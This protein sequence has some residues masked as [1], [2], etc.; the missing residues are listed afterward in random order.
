MVVQVYYNEDGDLTLLRGKKIAIIG[1]GNQAKAF[2]L[3]MRD[4][5][6]P[7]VVGLPNSELK[8][9]VERDGFPLKDLSECIQ[10][11]D[12]L[13][14][15][16]SDDHIRKLFEKEIRPNL[17]KNQTI[18][19]ASGCLLAFGEIII[20]DF[21]DV[22]LISPR[23]PGI[24]IRELFLTKKGFFS[25]IGVHQNA[26][27]TAKT[28]LLALTK[29]IGGL[30][31]PAVETTFR[32]QAIISLFTEQTFIYALT[33]VLMRSLSNIIAKG[34]PPEAVFVEILLSGEAGFTIDKIVDVGLIKQMSFHS[35]TSQ[36]GQM[37][38]GVKFMKIGKE[39][40]EIQQKVME[41]IESGNFMKE[42][43]QEITDD[44]INLR[45]LKYYSA[46]TKFANIES[47]VRNN[48]G[49]QD[50]V[51]IPIPKLPKQE[52]LTRKDRIRI[53]QEQVKEFF[54]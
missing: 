16:I 12:V 44:E 23:V 21:I 49:F 17:K 36:Y 1:Y 8:S 24:G 34:Y 54:Q 19:F 48:L 22:L 38:R 25:F 3:N 7:I 31:R 33:Q 41:E 37:S 5:G 15:M 9:R 43:N 28:Q 27:G 10:E 26:S 13:F 30:I 53:N 46:T 45:I 14:L 2:A 51:S 40:E 20:P 18:V 29:A 50:A 52:E 42:W 11:Y 4:N 47:Q 35:Q 32:Q 6:I 39:V